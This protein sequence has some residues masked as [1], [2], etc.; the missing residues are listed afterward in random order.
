MI[1]SDSLRSPSASLDGPAENDLPA[2]T[3]P[4]PADPPRGAAIMESDPPP[5]RERSWAAAHLRRVRGRRLRRIAAAV[6]LALPGVLALLVDMRAGANWRLSVAWL[7]IYG[8]LTAVMV[9]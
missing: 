2:M 7:V 8:L 1:D 5:P 4:V 9:G 3:Q 6:A